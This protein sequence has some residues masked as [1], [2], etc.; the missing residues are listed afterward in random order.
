M[1]LLDRQAAFA[2]PRSSLGGWGTTSKILCKGPRVA[3]LPTTFTSLAA[4]VDMDFFPLQD[5]TDDGLQSLGEYLWHWNLCGDC[6]GQPI[7]RNI[8]CPWSR[9]ERLRTFWDRY[10]AVTAAYVPE[11]YT[12]RPALSSHADL[13]DVIRLIQSRPHDT[14]ERLMES[15]FTTR[16]TGDTDLP[17]TSDQ[18]R[19]MHLGASILFSV[20]CGLSHEHAALL[21]DGA[22]SVQWRNTVS[23]NTFVEEAFPKHQDPSI[24]SRKEL[25]DWPNVAAALSAKQLRKVLGIH[26]KATTDLRSHLLFDHKR[27]VLHI[28]H[29]TAMLKETLLGSESYP[30]S[31][32][33]P[34]ELILEVF[35]T[36][37]NVLFPPDRESQ[38]LLFSLVAKNGFD[39]DILKF[40]MPS[41]RDQEDS[42]PPFPYF[43]DRLME[44]Y[45]EMQNPAPRTRL[46]SWFERKSGARYMLMATMIGVFIAVIIGILGL[47]LSGFQAYVSYQQWK[48][49]VNSA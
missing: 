8:S 10:R 15:Y 16:I 27:G 17:D 19:A 3:T 47:G 31:C 22:S 46:E 4:T 24:S 37:H 30:D 38:S 28:F 21:E 39:K 35:D 40:E 33:L 43:A 26:L 12:S 11:M 20:N 2:Q 9:A 34:R 7:C 49:P 44:L 32:M 13:R 48:H 18:T 41:H 25:P 23:A 42:G 36:I 1:K 29:C 6:I 5:V 45:G 14:R